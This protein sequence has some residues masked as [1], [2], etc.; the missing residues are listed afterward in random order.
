MGKRDLPDTYAKHLKAA[1]QA[2]GWIHNYIS[3]ESI[4]L[5]S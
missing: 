3:G 2:L 4:V 5:I 1:G